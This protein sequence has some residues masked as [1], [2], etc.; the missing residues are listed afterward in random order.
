MHVLA[1]IGAEGQLLSAGGRIVK[2]DV[3]KIVPSDTMGAGDSFL[4]AFL[5]TLMQFG[6]QKNRQMPEKALSAAVQAG[7]KASAE[8][9]MRQGGFGVKA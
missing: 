8:N 7:Q 2:K 3:Q 4:A 1:T 9:C 6:W 5:N